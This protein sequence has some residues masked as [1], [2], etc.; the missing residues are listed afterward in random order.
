MPAV[1]PPSEDETNEKS[2]IALKLLPDHIAKIVDSVPVRK[3]MELYGESKAAIDMRIA[4]G[5]WRKGIEYGV[6]KGGGLWISIKAVNEWA[7]G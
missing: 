1:L 4:R 3:Y 6:P 2:A 7:R 5:H